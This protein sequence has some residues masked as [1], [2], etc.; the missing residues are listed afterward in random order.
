LIASDLLVDSLLT[1]M[2]L[3][4]IAGEDASKAAPVVPMA[5]QFSPA[6]WK[7]PYKDNWVNNASG[8]FDIC[9]KMLNEVLL[10][11]VAAAFADNKDNR[12]IVLE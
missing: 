10:E 11:V 1:E 4:E 5:R 7:T 8:Y 6:E 12:D 9:G 3:L 2:D